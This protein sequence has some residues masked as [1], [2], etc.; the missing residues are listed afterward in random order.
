M[1]NVKSSSQQAPQIG[2]QSKPL[3]VRVAEG[4]PFWILSDGDGRHQLVTSERDL[5]AELHTD[6]PVDMIFEVQPSADGEWSVRSADRVLARHTDDGTSRSLVVESNADLGPFVAPNRPVSRYQ[7]LWIRRRRFSTAEERNARLA[8][9]AERFPYMF[10]PSDRDDLT[11]YSGWFTG[12]SELCVQVD[13]L[14]GGD[15]R[16]FRWAVAKEKFG[17]ARYVY[18][19][20]GRVVLLPD[21]H[22]YHEHWSAEEGPTDAVAH[23]IRMKVAQARDATETACMVCGEPARLSGLKGWVLCLCGQHSGDEIVIDVWE[24]TMMCFEQPRRRS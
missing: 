15:K 11:F 9:L 16:G 17:A 6:E 10:H 4:L 14:L 19:I 3:A 18:L 21:K 7:H 8:E 1:P 23:E 24:L 12:F 22:R 20:D 2:W 13:A 5:S